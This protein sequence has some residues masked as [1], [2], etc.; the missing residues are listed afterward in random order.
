MRE[1]FNRVEDSE[2]VHIEVDIDTEDFQDS[3]PWLFS[4][5][6]KLSKIDEDSDAFDAFLETKESIIIA[7]EHENR[8]KYVGSRVNEGWHE[9]YF[10]AK[11]S[12]NLESIVAHMLKESGYKY[13]SS[14]V[15]DAKWD[16]YSKNLFPTELE[17][18]NIQSDKI[19]FLLQEEG[20]DLLI[21]RDVEHYVSF[22]TS[23]QKERFVQNALQNGFRFKDDISSEEFE[24]GAALL[25]EHAVT[26]KE[27]KKVVEELYKLVKKEHGYYE[28]WS[29]T[30]AIENN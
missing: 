23:S 17:F 21:S 7:L 2:S 24:Y 14:I 10:Y 12:K 9:F 8:A 27:I 26:N 18:H 6:I 29:T 13:E 5:F 15:K 25:K 16:F 3:N 19:I 20:D 28:G 11:N 22:D 1:I 4:L 30:L